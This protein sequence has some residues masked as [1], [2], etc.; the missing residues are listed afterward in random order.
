MAKKINAVCSWLL[1]GCLLGHLTTM[2]YSMLTG[3]YDYFICK[4]LAHMTAG[5]F[6]LHVILSLCI[7]FFLHDGTSVSYYWR[8][9]RKT[10]L[11]RAGG[12][13]MICLVHSHVKNYGFIVSGTPL[14]P[15]SKAG[16]IAA[17]LLFWG[18]LFTHTALS[19]SKS[20]ISLG[21][22][23]TEKAERRIDRAAMLICAM[24]MLL[25]GFAMT[26]FIVMW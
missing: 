2:S 15:L 21:L 6:F 20:C 7:V 26:R 1:M 16:M 3:W 13:A 5:V 9:N 10:M 24:L 25:A 14:S 11:Q 23:R 18:C 12:V 8:Q 4:T 17:E 22:I 19:V